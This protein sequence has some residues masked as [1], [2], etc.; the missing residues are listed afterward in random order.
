MH[1]IFKN[2]IDKTHLFLEEL[3]S[4]FAWDILPI[5][6]MTTDR[7][8]QRLNDAY[9]NADARMKGGGVP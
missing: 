3:D 5:F 7:G 9:S 6:V 2:Q 1:D 4:S 8:L